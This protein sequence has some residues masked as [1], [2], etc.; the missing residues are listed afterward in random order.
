MLGL[1][2]GPRKW[3]DAEIEAQHALLEAEDPRVAFLGRPLKV[4]GESGGT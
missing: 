1:D 2:S 4:K 3:S